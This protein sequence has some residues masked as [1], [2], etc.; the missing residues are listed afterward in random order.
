MK[1]QGIINRDIAGHLARF[2]HT[3]LLVIA[4]CGLPVPQHVPCVDL[5]YRIGEPSFETVL[6]A[7]LEDFEAEAAYIAREISG[8]NQGLE[9]RMQKQ[10]DCHYLSHEE[11]KAMSHNAKLIVRTGEASPYANVIL[12]SGV[13]F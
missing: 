12:Q 7:V 10:L 4:D 3:D 5:S 2:G 6:E 9:A 11:L 8:H 1:K 13:I